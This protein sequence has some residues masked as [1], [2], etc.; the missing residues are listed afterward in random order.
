MIL[1]TEMLNFCCNTVEHVRQVEKDGRSN[2][3][4]KNQTFLVKQAT[5]K[6]FCL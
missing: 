5:C 2:K 4:H 1:L 3:Q 6:K